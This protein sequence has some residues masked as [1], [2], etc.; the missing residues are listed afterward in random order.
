MV[1]INFCVYVRA[2]G[3]VEGGE[4]R[5]GQHNL[6]LDRELANLRESLHKVNVKHETAAPVVGRVSDS[7]DPRGGQRDLG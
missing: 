3:P 4:T 2:K 5:F 6:V 7:R 1:S